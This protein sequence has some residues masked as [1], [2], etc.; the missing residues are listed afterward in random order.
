MFFPHAALLILFV[1]SWSDRRA[2]R[3]PCIV[4]PIIGQVITCIGLSLCWI[5]YEW[6]LEAAGVVES[7]FS[8]ITGGGMVMFMGTMSYISDITT[9]EERTFRL[10]V[11]NLLVSFPPMHFTKC[12]NILEQLTITSPIANTLSGTL[13]KPLGFL[14]IFALTGLIFLVGFLYGALGLKESRP[15]IPRP[16][17]VGFLCDLFNPRSLLDTLAVLTKKRENSRRS[18]LV[19]VILANVLIIGAGRGEDGLSYLYVRERFK[20]NEVDYSYFTTFGI[21]IS[22]VGTVLATGVLSRVL[23]ISDSLICLICCVCHVVANC[24]NAF[25]TVSWLFYLGQVVDIMIGSTIIVARSLSSKFVPPE[26]FGKVNSLIGV[27]SA[28][29]QVIYA[30]IFNIFYVNTLEFMSG[31][32]YLLGA[33]LLLPPIGIFLWLYSFERKEAKELEKATAKEKFQYTTSAHYRTGPMV[34]EAFE[35]DKL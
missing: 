11:I 20:W 1:G 30:P 2:R 18:R 22:L 35:D 4:A 16:A 10:G 14:G 29:A 31:A 13:L 15:T 5:F 34:N 27:F 25:A 12:T 7:L 24:I 3:K 28:L 6:P 21:I 26:D 17:D 8:S 23:G 33:A 32:F 19:M 9:D